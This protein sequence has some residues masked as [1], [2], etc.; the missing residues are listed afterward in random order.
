MLT[1]S[2]LLFLVAILLSA[3]AIARADYFTNT[4][5]MS[6]PRA[7]QGQVLLPNGK[8][9]A[10][11]GH[12]NIGII[13]N[14]VELYDCTNHNW[15]T[16][17]SMNFKRNSGSLT[18]LQSGKV[19]AA[20]GLS[21]FYNSF[22]TNAEIY[23]PGTDGWTTTGPMNIARYSHTATLLA[24]GQVLVAGGDATNGYP[25][26]TELFDP[27]T[28]NW[29]PTGNLTTA[30]DSHTA[31]L[32]PNGKVA[33]IGGHNAGGLSSVEL[34]DAGTGLWTAGPALPLFGGLDAHTATLLANGKVL[35]AGGFGNS[36]P[37][38]AALVYD[39]TNGTWTGTGSMSFARYGHTATL[40]ASGKVLVVGGLSP[41]NTV[42]NNAEEY[43]P[44]Q[45]TWTVVAPM[46]T[47]RSYP[48]STLLPTG[49]VLVAG[50]AGAANT[51]LSNAELFVTQL[52]YPPIMLINPLKMSDGSFT[53]S[54]TNLSGTSFTV[55]SSTNPAVPISNWTVLGTATEVSPGQYQYSDTSTSGKLQSFYSVKLP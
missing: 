17:A 19:L 48:R 44:S 40:L 9:M 21:A 23:D 34:Y 8:V 32:L 46:Q 29:I 37:S 54:F 1:R 16:V 2:A 26:M 33:V 15:S 28:G 22:V 43:D 42:V 11:G 7:G 20:G 14:G 6:C 52:S 45:Q 53:F 39:V 36:G 51:V 3:A 35:V 50:G 10:A 25:A 13:T 18:L 5:S 30:R 38:A 24:N 55:F 4:A 31:T 49:Q 27:S 12:N 41:A 47:G